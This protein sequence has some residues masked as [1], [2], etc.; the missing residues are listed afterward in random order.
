MLQDI[1]VNTTTY[2]FLFTLKTMPLP[3]F[4]KIDLFLKNYLKMALKT[5]LFYL[6]QIDGSATALVDVYDK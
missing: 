1:T 5:I 6:Q 3:K 4:K 2:H